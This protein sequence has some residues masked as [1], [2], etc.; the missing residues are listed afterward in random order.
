MARLSGGD[1]PTNALIENVC[2]LRMHLVF[3]PDGCKQGAGHP[4]LPPG[5]HRRCVSTARSVP[6]KNYVCLWRDVCSMRGAISS[7]R[8]LATERHQHLR[9]G[10]HLRCCALTFFIFLQPR[11][12]HSGPC[13]HKQRNY[14]IVRTA[15]R[16]LRGVSPHRSLGPSD[17][18]VRHVRAAT[19]RHRRVRPTPPSAGPSVRRA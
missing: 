3:S 7:W 8:H 1:P 5:S 6:T 4:D 15:F 16:I 9:I 10:A 2:K 17:R 11:R 12:I 14:S 18:P 19:G 13:P